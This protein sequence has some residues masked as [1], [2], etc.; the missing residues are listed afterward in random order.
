LAD[1][2]SVGQYNVSM[3]QFENLKAEVK[4]LAEAL[5]ARSNNDANR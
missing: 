3:T 2:I 4:A 5:D 1:L